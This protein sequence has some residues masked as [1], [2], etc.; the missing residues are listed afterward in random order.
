MNITAYFYLKSKVKGLNNIK[1][2]REHDKI[3]E[4]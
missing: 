2:I 1:E 4:R 3:C